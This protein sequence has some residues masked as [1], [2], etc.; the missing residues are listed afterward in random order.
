MNSHIIQIWWDPYFSFLCHKCPVTGLYCSCLSSFTRICETVF[1]SDCPMFYAPNSGEWI[2][3]NLH[4]L[5]SLA[6][7]LFFIV[8]ILTGVEWYLIVVLNFLSSMA[9]DEYSFTRVFCRWYNLKA[10]KNR[11]DPFQWLSPQLMYLDESL[12]PGVR[13]RALCAELSSLNPS[14]DIYSRPHL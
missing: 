9:N 6:W 7:F 8:A 5:Q 12:A 10:G 2:Q 14:S 1:Q 4:P 3:F 13:G 11:A